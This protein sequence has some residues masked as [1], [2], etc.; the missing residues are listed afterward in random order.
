MKIAVVGVGGVGGY[1]GGKLALAGGD[2]SFLA[3]GA[4]LE[5]LRRDG[6][7]VSVGGDFAVR[8]PATNDPAE[9]GA[10][11]AVLFCVKSYDTEQA[12]RVLP[13]LLHEDTAVVSLQNGIDN[14]EKVAAAIGE[15]HVLG[16]AAYVFAE[17]IRPGVVEHR[18][19]PGTIAFGELDGGRT[20]RAERLVELCRAAE[21]TD[22]LDTNIRARLWSKYALICAQAGMTATRRLP[23]GEILADVEG[24]AMFRQIAEEVVTLAAAEGVGLPMETVEEIVAFVG[25]LEP[26]VRS[27]LY[28]DL[29]AG[30]RLELEALHGAAVRIARAHGSR[31]P[32]CESVYA[33]LHPWASRVP[34]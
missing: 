9:I 21:I 27:S 3:R 18:G 25:E 32:A 22:E 23:I 1:F 12:A 2:V 30:R 24:R 10:C 29:V 15:S 4:H 5:A 34:A 8:A 16:G 7:V 13:E 19:G 20:R 6:R 33:L 26:S 11:D 14:E 17:L 28:D 31:V